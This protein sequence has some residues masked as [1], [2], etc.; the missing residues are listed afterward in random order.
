MHFFD[1][2]YFRVDTLFEEWV[3]VEE[4]LVVGEGFLGQRGW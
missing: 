2:S 1:L 3:F 4:R